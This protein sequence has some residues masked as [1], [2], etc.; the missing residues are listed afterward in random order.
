MDIFPGHCN[1]P[2]LSRMPGDLT[3]L[4]MQTLY[5]PLK[6]RR[7]TTVSVYISGVRD[8]L[9]ISIGN[10]SICSDI[11]HKY[12]EQYFEIVIRNFTGR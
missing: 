8:F 11:W 1:N 10:S 6:R 2:L 7:F 5:L 4:S 12:Y 9:G 3:L